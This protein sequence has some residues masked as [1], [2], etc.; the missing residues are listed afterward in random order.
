MSDVPRGRIACEKTAAD[1]PLSLVRPS[2]V[3][4]LPGSSR[5]SCTVLPAN[6][7]AA[8]TRLVRR[9]PVIIRS[10]TAGRTPTVTVV[11]PPSGALALFFV[12]TPAPTENVHEPPVV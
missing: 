11:L 10:D 6:D 12:C 4:W 9:F 3:Q 1:L 8:T 2:V 7:L 5:C